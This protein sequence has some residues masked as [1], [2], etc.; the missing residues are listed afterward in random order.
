MGCAHCGEYPCTMYE[1]DQNVPVSGA[2]T[3]EG[4]LEDD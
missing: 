2:A 4:L 3:D 1:G